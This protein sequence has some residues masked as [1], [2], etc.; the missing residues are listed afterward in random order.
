MN[1]YKTIGIIST[2]ITSISLVWVLYEVIKYVFNN[3]INKQF[4][5]N[6]VWFF[7][8]DFVITLVI[9]LISTILINLKSKQL[10]TNE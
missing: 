4:D 6:S 1:I 8:I 2:L 7:L 10:T 9:I 5:W 3:D